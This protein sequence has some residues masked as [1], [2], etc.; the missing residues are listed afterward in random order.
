MKNLKMMLKL[1]FCFN[2]FIIPINA[3]DNC[4]SVVSYLTDFV[5][6]KS[7]TKTIKKNKTIR[8]EQVKK[9]IHLLSLF[10]MSSEKNHINSCLVKAEYSKNEDNFEAAQKS[11]KITQKINSEYVA[12]IIG[13]AQVDKNYF[14]VFKELPFELL[15]HKI[16]DEYNTEFFKPKNVLIFI[17]KLTV[18]VMDVHRAGFVHGNIAASKIFIE[19]NNPIL[20]DFKHSAPINENA[21]VSGRFSYMD[22]ES[23]T[24]NEVLFN[25]HIDVYS[26]GI[27]LYRMTQGGKFPFGNTSEA[28]V[29]KKLLK[30]NYKIEE[31]TSTVIVFLI[32]NLLQNDSALRYKPNK[33]LSYIEKVLKDVTSIWEGTLSN[34]KLY[35]FDDDHKVI[36][37]FIQSSSSGNSSKEKA[38]PELADIYKPGKSAQRDNDDN[39]LSDINERKNVFMKIIGGTG[40]LVGGT[41][42]AI[43]G[44]T[45]K[46]FVGTVD[47]IKNIFLSRNRSLRSTQKVLL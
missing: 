44:T 37:E 6:D 17:Y 24:N 23:L 28:D 21:K 12:Q 32:E 19:G 20:Y 47:F 3:I 16:I 15:E 46:A 26:I 36:K 38:N 40:D 10:K 29:T 34:K 27:I 45:K 4:K 42:N 43:G 39:I 1:V 8:E 33:I 22:Y 9:P 30:G 7:E 31:E 13:Y 35:L 11:A 2:M 41:A 25:Y 14:T 18:A 5:C